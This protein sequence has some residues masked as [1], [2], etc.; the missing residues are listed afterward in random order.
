MSTLIALLFYVVV[1]ALV[2]IFDKD[3]R[4]PDEELEELLNRPYLHDTIDIPKK[5]RKDYRKLL[6]SLKRAKRRN[7][8]AN[9][10]RKP[11]E[12]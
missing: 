2:V 9:A 10:R 3:K 7:K 11:N 4:T 1:F 5:R 6:N 12:I 8:K